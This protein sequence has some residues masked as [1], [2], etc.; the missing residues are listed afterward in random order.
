MSVLRIEYFLDGTDFGG[1]RE[2]GSKIKKQILLDLREG[3]GVTLD[4][5]NVNII[6]QSFADEII[7][8]LVREQGSKYVGE[9]IRLVNAN[10][11]IIDTI[12]FVIKYSAR[13]SGE[14]A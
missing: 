7:G 6:T 11:E 10:Q 12:N 1:T 3:T 8:I 13:K 14:V 9:N 2:T 5:G 4:F